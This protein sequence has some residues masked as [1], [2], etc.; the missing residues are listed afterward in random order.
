MQI[1][2]TP[3]VTAGMRA[4][5]STYV[6][7]INSI[8][9][10]SQSSGISVTLKSATDLNNSCRL[11]FE[12]RNHT[13]RKILNAWP[14]F[15]FLN[16]HGQI[17]RS[18]WGLTG[19]VHFGVQVSI[20]DSFLA[21]HSCATIR[22][23][24]FRYTYVEV[25]LNCHSQTN[26]QRCIITVRPEEMPSLGI[27]PTH[28]TRTSLVTNIGFVGGVAPS[29]GTNTGAVSSQQRD[30][31]PAAS[32]T[33]AS[34]NTTPAR[35]PVNPQNIDLT[36]V[37]GVRRY[38]AGR[39]FEFQDDRSRTTM[40]YRIEFSFD[41]SVC[42]LRRREIDLTRWSEWSGT[43]RSIFDVRRHNSTGEWY[44]L[45]SQC[46]SVVEF[47]VDKDGPWVRDQ[48]GFRANVRLVE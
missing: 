8:P 29:V 43:W 44:I 21:P 35:T 9:S 20:T 23:I 41:A 6:P 24:D 42:K 34:S 39:T 14:R 7:P 12:W 30:A 40:V 10:T 18:T 38:V 1:S 31:P 17:L 36:T 4:A 19:T 11:V 5:L 22:R 46:H 16:E 37:E 33:T 27:T 48:A 26:P 28:G 32:R 13:G 25:D 15:S 47:L 3:A 2:L 45:V